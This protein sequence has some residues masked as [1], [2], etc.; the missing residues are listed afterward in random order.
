MDVF[1]TLFMTPNLAFNWIRPSL[2]RSG[3]P[4]HDHNL[5]EVETGPLL[6]TFNIFK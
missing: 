3:L 1:P 6:R 5:S 2:L 4:R